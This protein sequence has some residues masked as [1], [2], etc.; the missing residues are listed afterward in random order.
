MAMFT[1][2]WGFWGVHPFNLHRHVIAPVNLNDTSFKPSTLHVC[3]FFIKLSSL[4][5]GGHAARSQIEQRHAFHE[6]TRSDLYSFYS[7]I[8]LSRLWNGGHAAHFSNK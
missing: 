5:N 7:S 4:L 1:T 8:E 6:P 2:F 3:Y